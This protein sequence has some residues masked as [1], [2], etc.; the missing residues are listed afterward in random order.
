MN[1]N[2]HCG[3]THLD[4]LAQKVVAGGYD[5]GVAFDGDADRCLL[6]DEQGGVIDGDKVLAVCGSDMKRR[7][8]LS[9]GTIVATVMSNLG[10]HEFC[11]ENGVGLVCTSVGDRNVLEKMNECGYK[12]GGEQSGHTIFTDYATTGDGQLTALQFLDVLARSGKKASEL[13]SVCRSIRRCCSTSPFRM[14]AASRM[15]SW[16]PMHSPRPSRRRRGSSPARDACSSARAARKRSSASWLRQ[17]QNKSPFL[18]P[19]IWSM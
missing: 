12:L 7:G 3:S 14:S 8:K 4:D 19:R 5:I 10:L 18:R 6:V 9:G 15:P 2:D 17:K 1:I 11:R 13:A 16:H